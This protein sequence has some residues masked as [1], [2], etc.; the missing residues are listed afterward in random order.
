MGWPISCRIRGMLAVGLQPTQYIF[1]QDSSLTITLKKL[2]CHHHLWQPA[3][4]IF[5]QASYLR[6]WFRTAFFGRSRTQLHLNH[7]G[8]KLVRAKGRMPVKFKRNCAKIISLGRTG[9]AFWTV[10]WLLCNL[11][12]VTLMKENQIVVAVPHSSIWEVVSPHHLSTQF[13]IKV[14]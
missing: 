7:F 1:W 10:L 5:W 11:I 6:V 9:A 8:R 2:W 4:N 14:G 12:A 3:T 13:Q